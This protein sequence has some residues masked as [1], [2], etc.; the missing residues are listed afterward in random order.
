MQQL[1]LFLRAGRHQAPAVPQEVEEKLEVLHTDHREHTWGHAEYRVGGMRRQ[2]K[3]EAEQSVGRGAVSTQHAEARSFTCKYGHTLGS[4][5]I[6]Y[7]PWASRVAGRAPRA[8][9][10]GLHPGS[11]ASVSSSVVK[12]EPPTQNVTVPSIVRY[13]P[14]WSARSACHRRL[15]IATNS[16][17]TTCAPGEAF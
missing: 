17:P 7:T 10:S 14:D 13:E 12:N 1:L 2:R 9:R 15:L 4:R 6:K 16:Q 8:M 3:A 11:L 5:S